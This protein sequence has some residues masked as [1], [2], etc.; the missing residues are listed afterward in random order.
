M[1]TYPRNSPQAAARIVALVLIADGHVDRREEAVLEKLNIS[2]DLGL[3]P[4]EFAQIVQMLCEDRSIAHAASTPIAAHIDSTALDTLLA[5][6]DDPV[7]RRKTIRLSLAVASAD[8]FLADGEIAAIAAVLNAWI[9]QP[10]PTLSLRATTS[11][12]HQIR[13]AATTW[14][15]RA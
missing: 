6:V 14:D 5:E 1:R 3:A 7:L 13:A 11:R 2:R 12:A 8:N 9:L 4:G 10:R 15:A